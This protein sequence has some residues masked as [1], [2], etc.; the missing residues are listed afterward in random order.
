MKVIF[1]GQHK[2]GVGKTTI[3]KLLAQAFARA[4]FRTLL[5]DMD[6]Q[7]N[8][9]KRFLEMEPDTSEL[10]G[11]APPVHPD[12]DPIED[13]EWGGRS[14][15]ADIYF[16]AG[17]VPYPTPIPNLDILPAHAG[18]LRQVEHVSEDKVKEKV[19]ERLREFLS[20]ADV[21]SSYDICIIDTPPSK[22]ALT[23]SAARAAT[24]MLIPVVMEQMA[25]EGLQGM[26]QLWR[27]ENR[28]R[29]EPLEIIGILPNMYRHRTALH[30]G[31]LESL[32]VHNTIAPH[33]LPFTFGQRV[34][35][36]ETDVPGHTPTSVF[37]LKDSDPARREA[38]T[39]FAHVREAV[40]L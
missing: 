38:E 3:A 33:L 34:I 23:I 36:A 19:H 13:R 15:I 7:C 35:F 32:K 16:G 26:L 4:G 6:G 11:F 22:G 39:L 17:A 12:Y 1:V 18:P 5:I 31:M 8:M 37:D 21:R 40:G 14:S 9:S 2:G 30:A 24:H 27:R 20:G 25:V 28:L 10:G 29:S